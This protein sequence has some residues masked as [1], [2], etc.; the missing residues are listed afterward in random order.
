MKG[1]IC[2]YLMMYLILSIY[3]N[4]KNYIQK[5]D[6]LTNIFQSSIFRHTPPAS[7]HWGS[8]TLEHSGLGVKRDA[9]FKYN[10]PQILF[11]H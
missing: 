9:P 3:I 2:L 5:R 8:S 6:F 11:L 1:N 4:V 7:I 10:I